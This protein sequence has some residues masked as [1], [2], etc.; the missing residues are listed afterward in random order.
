LFQR[1]GAQRDLAETRAAQEVL[2]QQAPNTA[3]AGSGENQPGK[4]RRR[5]GV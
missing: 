3:A 4:K 5:G 2:R 1:L